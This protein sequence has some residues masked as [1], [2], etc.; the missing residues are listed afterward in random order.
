MKLTELSYID[1]LRASKDL[2]A[3]IVY[4]QENNEVKEKCDIGLILGNES[5]MDI[6]CAKGIELYEQGLVEKLAVSGGIGF[7]NHDR[8]TP[9][10]NK[11]YDILRELGIPDKDIIVENE[12]R[13]TKENITNT[14]KIVASKYSNIDIKNLKYALITSDFHLR[15]GLGLFGKT[16]GSDKNIFG[17]G[18]LDGKTDINSWENFLSTKITIYK[19]AITLLNYAKRG[20]FLHDIYLPELDADKS[21]RLK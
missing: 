5:L 18:V 14:L 4:E 10:A 2:I 13:D 17:S 8:K 9:E 21:L 16:I 11:M 3:D 15:R 1:I 6:R 20:K 12:S 7:L 19:E